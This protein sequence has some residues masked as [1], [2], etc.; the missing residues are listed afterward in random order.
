M[1]AKAVMKAIILA[2]KDVGWSVSA[3]RGCREVWYNPVKPI[4]M[5]VIGARAN[6]YMI[7]FE[8]LLS[9]M[10]KEGWLT[11]ADLGIS[12]FRTMK[13]THR[14]IKYAMCWSNILLFVE[15]DG[16]YVHLT[17]LKKFFNINIISGHGW[18][19]TAGIE[20]ILNMLA[21]KGVT[22]VAVFTLTDYDPFGFAIDREFVNKCEVLGLSV[23]DHHRVGINVEH[24]PPEDLEV[25]KYPVKRGRNLSVD[26]ISFNSDEWLAQ[27]GID[28]KYGLEIEA[29]SAQLGGHQRLREIVAEE[30]MKYLEESDR[31]E[32]IT[33]DAWKD[34][35][36][37]ALASCLRGSCN[38]PV[39]RDKYGDYPTD[40]PKEYIT[41]QY[42]NRIDD[43][44]IEQR[45]A[46]T[47]PISDKITALEDE[48]EELEVEK[49]EKEAPYDN[50]RFYYRNEYNKSNA[51]LAYC[52]YQ[53]SL[54]HKDLFPREKY[55]LGFP[56]GCLVE[57]VKENIS[58]NTLI[59]KLSTKEPVQDILAKLDEGRENGDI[60]EMIDKIMRGDDD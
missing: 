49:L 17:A 11:Y 36:Y 56:E 47:K 38:D 42:F 37:R 1:D 45:D 51:I 53:Y 19:N 6:G 4:L 32:E 29:V 26:G 40:L 16:A 18:S 35:P 12:D 41:W 25:Q 60:Q 7:P 46:E 33:K 59:A 5:R 20:K 24:S 39:P 22:E 27:Y 50:A 10:V 44:Y 3:S 13:E 48:I 30:L 28:G 55:D 34:V 8:Q 52:L 15:K 31:V 58:L 21:G 54:K 43:Y 9:K 2:T 57:A 14:D 23:T